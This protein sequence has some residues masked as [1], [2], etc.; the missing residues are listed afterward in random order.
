MLE[1]KTHAFIELIE[2]TFTGTCGTSFVVPVRHD[3]RRVSE[4]KNLFVHRRT[5]IS[6]RDASP[7]SH[8][9]AFEFRFPH[10]EEVDLSPNTLPFVSKDF[11]YFRY[12][13][14]AKAVIRTFDGQMTI[15]AE[16]QRPYFNC[17]RTA[18][19]PLRE[20]ERITSTSLESK[21]MKASI[22]KRKESLVPSNVISF[23]THDCAIAGEPVPLA[24]SL[25]M[26]EH[27]GKEARLESLTLSLKSRVRLCA[28]G[29]SKD[30]GSETNAPMR[31]VNWAANRKQKAI[32]LKPGEYTD[33]AHQLDLKSPHFIRPT[34]RNELV[35]FEYLLNIRAELDIGGKAHVAKIDGIPI[36]VVPQPF[37]PEVDCFDYASNPPS[38]LP[39]L[40]EDELYSPPESAPGTPPPEWTPFPNDEIERRFRSSSTES[41]AT[42]SAYFELFPCQ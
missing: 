10:Q 30:L 13:V 6:D 39:I 27:N 35:S 41:I 14:S 29:Q 15:E 11:F 17:S 5:L 38:V 42:D 23:R 12:E 33:I 25:P 20:Q 9:F 1:C 36:K 32:V 18:G 8:K 19:F 26:G 3:G 4:D 24:I 40:D 34:F 2:M 22:G 16:P 31:M 37:A 28:Q 21:K 7:G